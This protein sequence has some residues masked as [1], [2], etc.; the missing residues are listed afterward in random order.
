MKLSVIIPVH[1]GGDALRRCLEALA[2]STR[3]PDEVILVDDAS[4]D[5]SADLAHRHGARV[6]RL[7]GP[8]HGP[9]FA[10]NRG[11]EAAEGD[12]LLF[13]DADVMVHP[14]TLAR[15]DRHLTGHPDVDAL[16]GSYDADPPARGVASRYKNLLHHYVH[17][18]G[19][20]EAATFWAGCGAIRRPVFIR[21]GGFDEDY[22]RPAI[23]D[24]ELGARLRRAGYRIW[25]CPDVQV[26]HLKRWTLASLLRADI[27]DRAIPWTRLIVREQELPSD[28][29]VDVRSR[30]SAVVAWAILISLALGFLWPLA[31][32]GI[33][34][35]M[36][37]L[38]GLNADL[39]RF[40]AQQGGF[41]FAI[42]AGGLH[43]LYLLY[44]SLIFGL[45]AGPAWLAR[46]GLVLILLVTLFKGLTWSI[47]IPPWHAPDENDHF[48]YARQIAR[49]HSLETDPGRW[50]AVE[51][52]ALWRLA[53]LNDVRYTEATLDLAD[54]AGIAA[55]IAALDD[56]A[57]RNRYRYNESRWFDR[58]RSFLSFH[59]PLYY[60]VAAIAQW[61]LRTHSILV[62]NLV[63]R[64]LSVTLGVAAVAAAHRAGREL[65]PARPGWPLLLATLV[66]FQPMFTFS[67]S[68][69]G[70]TAL[71]I[72]FFS[73]ALVVAVRLIRQGIT[74]RRALLL[75]TLIGLGLLSRLSFLSILPL[76]GLVL[77]GDVIRTARRGTGWQGLWPWALTLILPLALSGWWYREALFSGGRSLVGAYGE[78]AEQPQVALLPFLLRYAWLTRYRAVLRMY[79]G[80]FGWLDAPMPESLW[81]ILEWLTIVAAWTTTWGLGRRI[82]ARR[83]L[84]A[85][86]REQALSLLMLGGA[87]LGFVAFYTYLDFRMAHARGGQFNLQGRYYLPA[88][89]GHMAWLAVG[90]TQPAPGRLRRLWAWIVGAGMIGLNLYA[91]LGVVAPRYYGSGGLRT[92]L[93]GAT[94]L[95]PVGAAALFGLCFAFLALTAGLLAALGAALGP[96]ARPK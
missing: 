6:I 79:W 49:F 22:D 9:A 28:L 7:E 38:I 29:N 70:N 75:G 86:K 59:P 67:T 32:V 58:Y 18:H 88:I 92:V 64:W 89:L 54:R 25:L 46:H 51:D 24:I 2:A 40:F 62:R 43:W 31:W 66:S 30:A 80:N 53:Q 65:W 14:D 52:G 55:E 68:I 94:V 33:A 35:G 12:V 42:A 78:I 69:V 82:A 76:L 81:I 90:T 15:I 10:R 47:V 17:Q 13:I 34:V 96:P 36:G 11:A 41:A 1:N 84:S 37:L 73:A 50:A 19:R 56:P 48:R 72:A 16:F 3:P 27:R 61:S 45:I 93:G 63:C 95:Q 23:E 60:A 83:R 39:Y 5:G 8:P 44:S 91:L 77:V 85:Q 87:T 4:T 20:R 74:L 57:T 26:A 21:M 71:E